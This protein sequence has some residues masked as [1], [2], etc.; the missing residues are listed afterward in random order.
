MTTAAPTTPENG[1]TIQGGVGFR[2][3][4]DDVPASEDAAS[5]GGSGAG[6]CSGS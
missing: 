5:F 1:A 2:F 4:F 6:A 3:G